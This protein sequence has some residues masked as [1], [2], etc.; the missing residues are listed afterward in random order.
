M[1]RKMRIWQNTKMKF[2][3][4]VYPPIVHS[5]TRLIGPASEKTNGN[6]EITLLPNDDL[7]HRTTPKAIRYNETRSRKCCQ[8]NDTAFLFLSVVKAGFMGN[9]FRVLQNS[10]PEASIFS[11]RGG[12]SFLRRILNFS[13][14]G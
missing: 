11:P 1:R 7:I 14:S 10:T 9:Y 6:E 12:L 3:A 13:T 8:R 4:I 5:G 2:I